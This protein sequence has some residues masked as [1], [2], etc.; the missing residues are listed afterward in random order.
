MADATTAAT[1]GGLVISGG[2][3]HGEPVALA[4]DF[5]KLAISELGAISERRIALLVDPRLNGG[6]PPVPLARQRPGVGDDAPP[7]HGRGP[8][9][10][11]QGPGPPGQRRFDP[12]F[13]QPGRPRLDGLDRRPPRSGGRRQRA[14]HPGPGAAG[15]RPGARPPVGPN[16]RDGRASAAGQCA[17]APESRRPTSDSI[18]RAAPGSRPPP[19]GR[20]RGRV[21]ARPRRSPGRS[22]EPAAGWSGQASGCSS[23]PGAAVDRPPQT[24]FAA[25]PA[26]S[27]AAPTA[28]A[29]GAG[30]P[31]PP[32]LPPPGRPPPET[33]AR[34]SGAAPP[35]GR[36]APP[37]RRAPRREPSG[38][39]PAAR[40][41]SAART[42]GPSSPE[43]VPRPNVA[44]SRTS[45]SSSPES[46]I[47]ASA[48]L[49]RQRL[50]ARSWPRR[51]RPP[52][53]RPSPR[54]RQGDDVR[55]R[56]RIGGVP[57]GRH[58][59]GHGAPGPARRPA[60]QQRGQNRRPGARIQL[61][62]GGP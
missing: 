33:R 15:G 7:V 52:A 26:R 47:S 42:S 38:R 13:G 57:Q 50:R 27:A 10:G 31:P 55:Q 25:S 21:R 6:L 20:H 48:R 34:G 4:L 29:A 30:R 56:R 40:A 49:G 58:D 12:H 51:R 44:Q 1:G 36:V 53:A 5:A 46:L 37:D 19:D 45:G 39:G 23:L 54:G 32:P 9:L 17:P 60:V 3:F 41:S 59:G 28:P 18:G 24:A 8:G 16:D 14:A 11:E 35:A 2:N 22:D 62:R 43:S 61:A